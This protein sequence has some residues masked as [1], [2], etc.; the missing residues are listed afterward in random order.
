MPLKPSTKTCS[1]QRK[2]PEKHPATAGA[3]L[4]AT[5]NL[6]LPEGAKRGQAGEASEQFRHEAVGC[7][8]AG[9]GRAIVI[10][11]PN[12]ARFMSGRMRPGMTSR[13]KG[14]HRKCGIE[15]FCFPSNA[16]QFGRST[17]QDQRFRSVFAEGPPCPSIFLIQ[18]KMPT[19]TA[20]ARMLPGKRNCQAS[21][22]QMFEQAFFGCRLTGVS[23]GA[24]R[25]PAS[26]YS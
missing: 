10:R 11:H 1:S 3:R 26:R 14:T 23:F 5:R 21:S 16:A 19:T 6:A 18:G 2:Q 7:I 22:G 25:Y 20:A 13:C 8:A 17:C 15:R 4:G 12:S 24:D 9:T